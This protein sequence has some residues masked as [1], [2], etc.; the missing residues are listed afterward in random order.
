MLIKPNLQKF[1]N[2][3][4]KYDASDKLIKKKNFF[5]VVDILKKEIILLFV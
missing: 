5:V 1:Y 2:K 4:N 3:K